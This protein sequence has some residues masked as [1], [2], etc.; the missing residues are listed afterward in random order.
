[1]L[2]QAQGH[3]DGVCVGEGRQNKCEKRM[4]E[5]RDRRLGEEVERGEEE[6]DVGLF[7]GDER[8]L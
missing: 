1:M 3:G 4:G 6:R 8:D 2:A 5:E 7:I